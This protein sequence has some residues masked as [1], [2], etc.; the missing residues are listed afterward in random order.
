M[1][2]CAR[3]ASH[4]GRGIA[5]G[6]SSNAEVTRT[7]P[8]TCHVDGTRRGT[9][10]TTTPDTCRPGRKRPVTARRQP[11]NNSPD[12]NKSPGA[13]GES[14]SRQ[15]LVIFWLVVLGK[16]YRSSASAQNCSTVASV[17]C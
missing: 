9:N 7:G 11:R 13:H 17:Q 3:A 10:G 8:S 1:R 6:W 12:K 4:C 14:D 5:I 15:L 2:I 16:G